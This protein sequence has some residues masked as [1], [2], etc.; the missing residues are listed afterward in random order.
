[1]DGGYVVPVH[2][3]EASERLLSFGV[4]L[5]WSF[6]TDFSRMRPQAQIDC[7]D[8]NASFA[9]TCFWSATRTPYSLWSRRA[10]HRSA[11]KL[12][13]AFASFFWLSKKVA[14]HR[15]FIGKH[16]LRSVVTPADLLQKIPADGSCFLKMDIEGSEYDIMEEVLRFHDRLSGMAIEFHYLETNKNMFRMCIQNILT[17]F[18]VTH[19]HVNNAGNVSDDGWPALLEITFSNKQLAQG[20]QR[21]AGRHY[22]H[23][24][25]EPNVEWKPDVLIEF[26]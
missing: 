21:F 7:Y 17:Y 6:E 15:H 9:Y 1:M 16:Q 12:P 20:L 5:D 14:L 11:W 8:K 23:A 3:I 13:W 10:T 2:V 22:S 18:E 24:A 4:S 19:V 25:D 26:T